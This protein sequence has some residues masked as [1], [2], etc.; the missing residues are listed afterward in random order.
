MFGRKKKQGSEEAADAAPERDAPQPAGSG[1]EPAA[2]DPAETI[3]GTSPAG[4]PD[5]GPR[6]SADVE[7][8]GSLVDLG[9][10]HARPAPGMELRL[11]LDAKT[12]D[13][14]GL[15][16]GNDDGAVQVQVF[17]AP[18]SSGIWDE[19]RSEI[20][21]M[22]AGNGGTVEEAEGTF[23]TEL[24]T[25]LAQPG[26]QG[27]TVFAPAVFAGV[28]GPRWFLRAVYSGA[29]AVDESARAAFDECVRSIVVT[30]GDEPRAPRE[31]LPLTM[32][33]SATQGPVELDEDGTPAG[34]DLKP[35]E[36]GP[37]ITEVR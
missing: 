5:G 15:Q 4:S 3:A 21:E 31:M 9:S 26:P 12:N 22:I 34:E 36:R 28:D 8:L 18:R 19:I 6:D 35:F 2:G 20:S 27:R 17:A 1:T 10:V 29:P 14:S 25:R 13:V 11:E 16:M 37:E 7:D 30:R 23:G 24:R 32:P 33:E